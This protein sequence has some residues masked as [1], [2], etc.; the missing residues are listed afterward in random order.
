MLFLNYW[1]LNDEV[2]ISER[3]EAVEKLKKCK[4]FP[5]QNVEIIRFDIT[6]DNWGVTIFE[7]D[8]VEDGRV[9]ES[10]FSD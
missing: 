10:R 8:S 3:L 6:A 5:P 1:E 4:L 9:Y 2:S 7:A